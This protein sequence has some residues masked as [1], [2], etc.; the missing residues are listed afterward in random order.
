M[1]QDQDTILTLEGMGIPRYSARGLSQTLEPIDA[2]AHI[3]RTV[4][5]EL[6][7]FGYD[8]FKK[9]KTSISGSDQRPPAVDGVWPGKIITVD[10]IPELAAMASLP[11]VRPVVEGSERTEEGFMFYR[12]RL[13]MMVMQFS[14]DTDEWGATVGWT[15]Q[16]EEV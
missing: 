11:P 7:D 16:A 3:E 10:C 15:L 1:N 8:P 6:I 12:P 2:A 14:T 9:Y 5:G 13:V 4:N